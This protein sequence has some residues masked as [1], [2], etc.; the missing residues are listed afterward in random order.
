MDQTAGNPGSAAFLADQ[1][2]DEIGVVA[3]AFNRMSRSLRATY[4]RLERTAAERGAALEIAK[5][6]AEAARVGGRDQA[7]AQGRTA[8]SG[9]HPQGGEPSSSGFL[10]IARTAIVI[11]T[12]A[13]PRR[14][15][16]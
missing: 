8:R 5:A 10:A 1:G 3:D 2:K 15:C 12:G 14:S 16:G 9:P 11:P 7:T 6:E 4:G 13:A